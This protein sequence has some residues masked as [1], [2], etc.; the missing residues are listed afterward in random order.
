[1]AAAGEAE[2]GAMTFEP[3]LGR[4]EQLCRAVHR[5]F[6]TKIHGRLS[7]SLDERLGERSSA[8]AC[9]AGEVGS[10]RPCRRALEHQ[11]DAFAKRESARR[12]RRGG[13]ASSLKMAPNEQHQAL[14]IRDRSGRRVP[15]SGLARS[16]GQ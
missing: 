6:C 3:E 9:A 8:H 15:M 7:E 13:R 12:A 10:V 5:A 11:R 14:L 2:T 1:M 16:L 4:S